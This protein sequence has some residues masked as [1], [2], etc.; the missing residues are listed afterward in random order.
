MVFSTAVEAVGRLGRHESP[1]P[2][3]EDARPLAGEAPRATAR[4]RCTR[5]HAHA[6]APET[7]ESDQLRAELSS[8]H[9]P[10]LRQPVTSLTTRTFK[11]RCGGRGGLKQLRAGVGGRS[12]K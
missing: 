1:P 4:T 9:L 7:I 2:A 5:T 11:A 3:V 8:A 10:T 12:R 6:F